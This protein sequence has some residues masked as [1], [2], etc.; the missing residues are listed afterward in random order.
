MLNLGK[1]VDESIRAISINNQ[2]NP[3][4]VS[5]GSPWAFDT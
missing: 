2:G 4:N 3:I 1:T 5:D